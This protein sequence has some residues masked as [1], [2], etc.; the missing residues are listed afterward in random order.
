MIWQ[1]YEKNVEYIMPHRENALKNWISAI[2]MDASRLVPLAGDASFRRYFRLHS[3]EKTYIAV[4][5][6]PEKESFL[7]FITIG[8]ELQQHN[9]RTPSIYAQN[10]KEGFLLIEDFGDQLLLDALTPDSE[11]TLYQQAIDTLIKI[12]SCPLRET[13]PLFDKAV[14]QK[15]L[16][17]FR[18][19]YLEKHLQ[20]P[21][22]NHE[23]NLLTETFEW[24]TSSIS[25]EP[26]V[27]IHRDYHSRNIMLFQDPNHRLGIIDFQDAAKGPLVYDLVS[28]IKDCY[29]QWPKEIVMKWFLYFY[30]QSD[31][32]KNWSL[33]FFLKQAELCSL[34]RHIKVL[35]I[36]AR[37]CHRDGKERYL[38]DIPLV[39]NYVMA[40]TE[41]IPEL[42]PFYEFLRTL[43]TPCM[44]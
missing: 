34:Q 39:W 14:M 5:I 9:I 25:L 21:L 6:P 36:F 18:D 17:L 2:E 3:Q 41:E 32:A 28:L 44:P 7:P 38:N 15:E 16:L 40:A 30:D 24:L 35:G 13:L 42:R 22:K 43:P 12:Q 33:P 29:I 26:L 31:I 1:L 10:E 8:N 37:L 4:D 11:G 27:F 20:I 19:W 23:K